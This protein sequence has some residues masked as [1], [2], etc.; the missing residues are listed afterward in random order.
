MNRWSF[1]AALLLLTPACSDDVGEPG[2]TGGAQT[3]E[4]GALLEVDVPASGRVF[5]RLATPEIVVPADDGAAST[6][7]DLALSGY[8]VFTNS[9]LSGPGG[10]TIGA[11]RA[12]LLAGVLPSYLRR[13][14]CPCIASAPTRPSFPLPPTCRPRPC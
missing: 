13:L 4:D 2:S 6:D 8:D 1:A 11:C 9:G 14:P 7:W 5:L 3:P 10:C 12:R